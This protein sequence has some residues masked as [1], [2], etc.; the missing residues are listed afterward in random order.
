M[1]PQST[2]SPGPQAD[3]ATCAEADLVELVRA[4]DEA[5]IAQLVDQ[6]SPVML[7]VARETDVS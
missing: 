7:R 1:M 6:W 3:D 4:G 2:C 5:A